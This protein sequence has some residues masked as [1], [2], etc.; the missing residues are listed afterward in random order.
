[1]KNG[2]PMLTTN[3]L[4]SEPSSLNLPKLMAEELEKLGVKGFAYLEFDIT[5]GP[6]LKYYYY[7][8]RASFIPKLVNNPAISVE[9]SIIGKYAKEIVTDNGERLMI[10]KISERE[11]DGRVYPHFLILELK[12]NKKKHVRKLVETVIQKTNG[13][14]KNVNV[15]KKALISSL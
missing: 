11:S 2:I 13:K 9:L 14:I 6:K 10:Y 3:F 1:M 8:G 12:G 5:L 4:L 15:L 7:G